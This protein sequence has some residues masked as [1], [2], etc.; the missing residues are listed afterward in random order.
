MLSDLDEGRFETALSDLWAEANEKLLAHADRNHVIAKGEVTITIK[1]AVTE[2]GEVDITHTAKSKLPATPVGRSHRWMDKKGHLSKTDNRQQK[3][4]LGD[5]P[6]R[7]G[8]SEGPGGRGGLTPIQG[9]KTGTGND[10]N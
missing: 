1:L 6:G 10:K 4:P 2:H 3:L 9:G 5:V 8:M 7:G